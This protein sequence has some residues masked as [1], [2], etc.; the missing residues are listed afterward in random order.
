MGGRDARVRVRVFCSLASVLLAACPP[1]QA[2]P[3]ALVAPDQAA[4]ERVVYPILMRDCA[5]NECHGGALR[6]FRVVGPGRARLDGS[7]SDPDLVRREKQLSYE[8]ARSMLQLEPGQT[9]FDARLLQK[10]LDLHAGGDRHGGIDRL[11][12]D[13]FTSRKDERYRTLLYW[14]LG[15]PIDDPGL[16]ALDGDPVAGAGG[17]PTEMPAGELS[18]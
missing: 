10:P 5:F 16:H 2:T 17:S 4:F 18:P 15:A 1:E 13:V 9:L 6:P 3:A 11:G 7:P 14:A 8:R 12:R